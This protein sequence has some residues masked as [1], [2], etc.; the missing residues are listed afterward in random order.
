MFVETKLCVRPYAVVEYADGVPFG[1]LATVTLFN[2][3]H[4]A[5][6]G[7]SVTG[8]STGQFTVGAHGTLR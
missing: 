4:V 3:P 1:A 5:V 7:V 6:R 8:V 2:N